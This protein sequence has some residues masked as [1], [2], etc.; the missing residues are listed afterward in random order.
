M[1]AVF[2]IVELDRNV[3][4]VEAIARRATRYS[5]HFNYVR[6]LGTADIFIGQVETISQHPMHFFQIIGDF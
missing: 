5:N 6:K 2:G 3:R 4:K 1:Q